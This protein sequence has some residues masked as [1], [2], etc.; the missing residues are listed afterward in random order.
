MG[1]KGNV[2]HLLKARINKNDEFYTMYKDIEKELINYDVGVFKGKVIFL[3]CD[4]YKHSQFYQY[5]KDNFEEYGVKEVHALHIQLEEDS[6]VYHAKL[7][8]GKNGKVKEEIVEVSEK[9]TGDFRDDYSIGILE[10]SDMVVTNP[11]FSLVREYVSLIEEYNKDIMIICS[12]NT[13]S[14]KEVYPKIVS[15]DL[16]LGVNSG[17]MRFVLPENTHEDNKNARYDEENN[18]YYQ[19]LGNIIWLTN[20]KPKEKREQ[21]ELLNSYRE[22]PLNYPKYYNADAIEVSRVA[23]IPKDYEGLMGVPITY[24]NKHNEDQF[25]IVGHGRE[26]R[27]QLD[28]ERLHVYRNGR[29][30]GKTESSIGDLYRPLKPKEKKPMMTYKDEEGNEY[31][32]VYSRYIIRRKV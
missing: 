14:Y 2:G 15:K 8:K 32:R 16:W 17:T 4:N 19:S 7:S 20:I 9:T 5:F 3:N 22:D 12:Q 11:P 29:K 10:K 26:E 13:V 21:I 6:K 23:E 24:I 18:F 25:E 30:T 31:R 28:K 1:K 27:L